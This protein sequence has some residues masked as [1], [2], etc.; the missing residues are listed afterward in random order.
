[1]PLFAPADRSLAETL[2]AINE[3]N[4]FVP[5]RLELE[6]RF[7]GPVFV[8]VGSA[9]SRVPD[10][11]ESQGVS[12][13]SARLLEG[14]EGLLGRARGRLDELGSRRVATDE[15]ELY[16][17]AAFFTLYYRWQE[18]L[19]ELAR[20]E[21]ARPA[22]TAE[23]AEDG[24]GQGLGVPWYPRFREQALAAL[25]PGGRRL[26]LDLE[27]ALLLSFFFQIARAFHQIYSNIIGRSDAA[28]RLRAAVW[29]SIFTHDIRRY[30]RSVYRHMR[31]LATLVTGPSGTGKELVARA[32][33]LSGFLPFDEER[34][35]FAAAASE[36]FLPLNLTALSPTLIESELFGHKRGA[37]TG[38]LGDRRGWFE[39]CPAH[40]AVFLD[41]IGEISQEIQLKLLRVLQ[42]R[43][44]Q[45]LGETAPRTF[46]GKLVSAT[47]R[48]LEDAMARG[49][50][51]ED[52][53][54]RICSDRIVTPSLAEQIDGSMDE[55]RVLALFVATGLLGEEA[56]D[57]ADEVVERVETS[58]G[59]DYPWPGNF[60]ELEQC[61]RNVLV[62]REYRP[63]VAG[64]EGGHGDDAR[65]EL[66]LAF[67]RGEKSADEILR[68][69]CT[70]VYA[71]RGSFDGAARVLG[72]DRRTVKA[73]VD[74]EILRRLRGA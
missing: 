74:P 51:R 39:A 46:R 11:Q 27:P 34:K 62:R 48:D 22:P 26:A 53:Y 20:A 23:R 7:L 13:N 35:S 47:N 70:L 10:V 21:A 49:T 8:D 69:Y 32:V 14:A 24:K 3:A 54:Y 58:L 56:V 60:R 12:P 41:E 31:D 55:L 40:G 9:R 16:E 57:L 43:A 59:R 67:E 44:F 19:T 30:Q 15:L 4:P 33:G 28:V 65:A 50:F 18:R 45:R 52:L 36:R 73:K 6:R 37:F 25:R 42:T 17:N 2:F 38:A 66:A 71:D 63:R 72:L 68:G 5:E 1:M 61:V 64:P 29:Q